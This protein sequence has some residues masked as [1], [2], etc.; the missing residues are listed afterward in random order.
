MPNADTTPRTPKYGDRLRGIHASESNPQRDGFYVETV[1]RTGRMN[2]G[3]SYRLTDGKGHFWEYPAESTEPV[4]ATPRTPGLEETVVR[5]AVEAAN[6]SLTEQRDELQDQLARLRKEMKDG[7][8]FSRMQAD[9][10]IEFRDEI[11]RLT[12]ERNALE[13]DAAR[14]RTE[15]YCILAITGT[16]P[17][18]PMSPETEAIWDR[19]TRIDAIA[20]RTL[21][22]EG[23]D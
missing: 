10:I 13:A 23:A 15:L 3:K 4:D 17:I 21:N 5:E 11:A 19:V 8:E 22:P 20:R 2:A 1:R 6:A 7:N 16:S 18:T 9:A 12:A 14:I